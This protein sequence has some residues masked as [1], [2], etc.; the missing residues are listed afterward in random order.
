MVVLRLWNVSQV[1]GSTQSGL[2]P[3]GLLCIVVFCSH[4]FEATVPA[5]LIR[6]TLIKQPN[7][8]SSTP[9]S[10]TNTNPALWQDNVGS[11][12]SS[13]SSLIPNVMQG[14]WSATSG[15]PTHSIGLLLFTTSQLL[16]QL[17]KLY[18]FDSLEVFVSP[19]PCR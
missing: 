11:A 1:A 18:S 12:D 14:P 5:L 4:F 8:Y 10:H 2:E 7:K 9:I 16:A 17:I 15:Q 6:S 19:I 3:C 13:F